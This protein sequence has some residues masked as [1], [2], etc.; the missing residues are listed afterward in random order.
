MI[1]LEPNNGRVDCEKLDRLV[2]DELPQ[3]ERAEL[4]T[5]LDS[6]PGGWR[7]CAMAFLEAQSWQKELCAIVGER[8]SAAEPQV[9]PQA[10][11]APRRPTS[12]MAT[13]T[14]TA[15]AMAASFVVAL[16]LGWAVQDLGHTIRVPG[17]GPAEIAES[18]PAPEVPITVRSLAQT[19]PQRPS[20]PSGP[21]QMVTLSADGSNG[22]SG[23]TIDVPACEQQRLDV[24]WTESLPSAL[25][26]DVVESL[27]RTGYRVRQRRE[28]LPVEMNDGRRLV[29]PVE[30]VEVEYAGQP[31][32]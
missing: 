7:R 4:L 32:L 13:R 1:P 2:D 20:S 29:V 11:R 24:G 28:L 31:S 17:P 23:R 16:W 25:P 15:L 14:A 30:E 21:W 26:L 19:P 5:K 12:R 3:E 27:R 10:T 8:F 9:P 22:Q 18:I 6:E